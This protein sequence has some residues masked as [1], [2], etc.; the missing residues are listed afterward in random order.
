[1]KKYLETVEALK[2]YHL[3]FDSFEKEDDYKK[4]FQ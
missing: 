4:Y 2:K 3:D 1:V